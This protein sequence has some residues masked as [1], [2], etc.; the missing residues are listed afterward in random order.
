MRLLLIGYN[1]TALAALDGCRPAGSVTLI[2]EEDLWH[3]KK[4]EP[5]AAAH[6]CL[7]TVRFARY[8]QDEQFLEVAAELGPFDAVVAGLEY[9]VLAAAQAA[10]AL[11]VAGAGPEAAAILRDKL[12]LREA[13]AAA[14]MPGPAFREIRSAADIAAFA[15]GGPCVVKPAGRQAS[16][17]VVL[18]DRGDDVERA[19]RYCTEADEGRQLARRPMRWRYLVEERLT[20]QEFS[21]EA[22]VHDGAVVFCNV[23]RKY[24]LPGPSPVETGHTVG[25]QDEQ[26]RRAV[27]RLVAAVG[28]GSGILHA[29]WMLTDAGPQLIECAARP[30][31]DRIM[32][33]IDLA[34]GINVHDRWIGMLLGEEQPPFPE[35]VRAAAVR[36][37]SAPGAGVIDQVHGA[38]A[39]RALPG[40]HRL[41]LS[42]GPGDAVG[43]VR[44]SWDR[45]GLVLTTGA[46]PDEAEQRA[47]AALASVAVTLRGEELTP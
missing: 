37:L 47:D 21:T 31:G 43:D 38:E 40:V 18:L 35:P 42:R 24:T 2:E 3:A 33:L 45:L 20:G 7:G 27:E 41:D 8:Q 26:W 17:G 44:S 9:A 46:T 23:T 14:G 16:L 5:R 15:D 36:F 34:Y 19:W 32:D 39:A 11:G 10:E 29:E 30:P 28:Y 1:D 25:P 12:L 6:P 13:T 4:L 22:L